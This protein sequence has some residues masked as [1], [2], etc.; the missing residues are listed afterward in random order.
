[1]KYLF[2]I[3]PSAGI[4]FIFWLAIRAIFQADRRERA[5]EAKFDAENAARAER[6]ENRAARERDVQ[7]EPHDQG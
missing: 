3:F 2:A 5:A 7:T 1:V 6:A 4:L